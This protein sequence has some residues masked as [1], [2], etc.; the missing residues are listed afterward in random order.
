[1]PLQT[2]TD[3]DQAF[4]KGFAKGVCFALLIAQGR[5]VFGPQDTDLQA[6]RGTKTKRGQIDLF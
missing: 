4:R 3:P 2:T 5:N 1:M 6:L